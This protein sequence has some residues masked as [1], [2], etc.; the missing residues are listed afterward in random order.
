MEEDPIGIKCVLLGE[1]GTGKSSLIERFINN[2]F[3]KDTPSTL[4]GSFSSKVVYYEK[5]NIKIRYDIWDTAGQE[6]YRSINKIFY[7][8]AQVTLLVY[9]ITQKETYDA[10]KNYWFQEVK[11]NAPE[12]VIV[13]IVGNK[14][15]IYEKEAVNEE[16]ARQYAKDINALYKLVSAE[17]GD[18]INEIF[19]MIGERMLTQ[20]F[21]E[22]IKNEKNNNDNNSTNNNKNTIKNISIEDNKGQ[23]KKKKCC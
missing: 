9:D 10:I 13:F 18:G 17:N 7:Q 15:D 11:D 12:D 14:S 21:L 1:S 19:K 23:K 16:E 5:E 2:T 6:K 4:I 8:D 20:E 3:R 22:K